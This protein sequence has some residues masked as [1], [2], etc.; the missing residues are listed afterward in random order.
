MLDAGPSDERCLWEEFRKGSDEAFERLYH[1]YFNHLYNYGLK[2]SHDENF[3]KDCIQE[4]FFR[5]WKNRKKLNPVSSVRFYL[6][7]TLR[8]DIARKTL[9]RSNR[10]KREQGFAD[11]QANITFSVE[12]VVIEDENNEVKK[13]Q[14]LDI[15]NTLPKKQREAIFLKY[16]NGLDY[17]EI[18]EIMSVKYQSVLNLIHRALKALQQNET[19]QKHEFFLAVLFLTNISF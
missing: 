8:Y 1:A 4:L 16:Y 17:S 5:L 2:L 14:L 7:K 19:L 6:L 18:A 12:E 9:R 3:T 10:Q 15:L 13:N 11:F